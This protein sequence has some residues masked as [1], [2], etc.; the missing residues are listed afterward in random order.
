HSWTIATP[1]GWKPG[2][3]P[4]RALR[5]PRDEGA[6]ARRGSIRVEPRKRPSVPEWEVSFFV[7]GPCHLG[8]SHGGVG[9]E[10]QERIMAL[11]RFW[12]EHACLVQQPSDMEV[13]AG[14]MPPAPFLRV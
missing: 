14:T 7:S 4:V 3:E 10:L 13:G 8:A 2:Q 6:R 12:S 5:S 9:M 1:G 11:D